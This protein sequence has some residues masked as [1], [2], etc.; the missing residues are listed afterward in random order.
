MLTAHA[1]NAL[2]KTLEE[3]P[4]REI[5]FATTRSKVLPDP[6]AVPAVRP[7][8]DRARAIAEHCTICG[9]EKIDAEPEALAAVADRADGCMRDALTVLDG[10]RLAGRAS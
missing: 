6:V 7:A 8:A 4:P 10:P 3:P 5:I 1:F 9:K 2:L